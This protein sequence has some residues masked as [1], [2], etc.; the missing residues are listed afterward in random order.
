MTITLA[1][2][3]AL[4]FAVIAYGLEKH[5]ETWSRSWAAVKVIFNLLKSKIGKKEKGEEDKEKGK[6]IQMKMRKSSF[7]R[8]GKNTII[9]FVVKTCN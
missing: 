5:Y 8:F 6:A 2:V 9:N 1:V 3:A 7:K 4:Q